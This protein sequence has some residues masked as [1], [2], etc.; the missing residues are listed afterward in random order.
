MLA[1]AVDASRR[2]YDGIFA[3]HGL[4]ASSDGRLWVAAGGE[5]PPFHSAVKTLGRGVGVD[6]VLRAMEPYPHGSVADSFGEF[7]LRSHG[8]ELLIDATWVG[9]R[10]VIRCVLAVGLECRPRRRAPGTVVP[11]AQLRRGVAAVDPPRRGV[12]GAGTPG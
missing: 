10:G 4:P 1:A 2:W 8:F 6:A 5:L 3:A 9:H 12:P 7:D 11:A